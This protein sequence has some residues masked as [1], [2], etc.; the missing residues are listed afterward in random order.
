MLTR[1]EFFQPGAIMANRRYRWSL[2]G[3]TVFGGVFALFA[4]WRVEVIDSHVIRGVIA[5]FLFG[6]YCA[7]VIFGTSGKQRSLSLTAQTLLGVGLACAIA[8]LFGANSDG[9]VAAALVGLVLGFTS[10]KWVEFI[11]LP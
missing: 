6:F 11:Q 2:L 1:A 7:I 10:D 4:F 5:A 8:A 3:A 9:Y